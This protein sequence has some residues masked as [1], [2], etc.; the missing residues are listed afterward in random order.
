MYYLI[1]QNGQFVSNIDGTAEELI[2]RTP[3]GYSTTIL[4]PPRS[5]DYWNGSN[6]VAIGSAPAYYF[7]FNYATKSWE[8]IRELSVVKTSKWNQIKL[9][10]NKAEFGGFLWEGLKFDSDQVSQGR[11]LAALIFNQPTEWTLSD[12]TVVELSVEDIQEVTQAMA[13][14]VQNV[15]SKA[16]SAREAINSATTI[17]EVESVLFNG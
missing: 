7:K 8:D 10:R 1:D 12:D 5:T 11:I 17:E 6:W 16:R 15:H 3:E 4:P 2:A 9:E 13:N 14:H